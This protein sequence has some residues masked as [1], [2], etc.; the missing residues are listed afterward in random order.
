LIH[1]CLFEIE[2]ATFFSY[3]THVREVNHLPPSSRGDTTNSTSCSAGSSGS[4]SPAS[5]DRTNNPKKKVQFTQEVL[6][7]EMSSERLIYDKLPMTS[8]PK[9][10]PV[11]IDIAKLNA[12]QGFGFNKYLP[13]NSDSSDQDY[14]QQIFESPYFDYRRAHSVVRLFFDNLLP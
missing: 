14:H 3:G 8:P 6:D 10:P 5:S 1:N 12:D 2:F 7:N 11:V 13:S 4:T 9:K